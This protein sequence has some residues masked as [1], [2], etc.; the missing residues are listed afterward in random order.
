MACKNYDITISALDIADATGNTPSSL[1]GRV[2]VNYTDCYGDPQTISYNT[3]GSYN[4]AICADDTY[5]L[6]FYYNKNNYYSE[7]IKLREENKLLKQQLTH[8]HITIDVLTLRNKEI[9]KEQP[10]LDL[11]GMNDIDF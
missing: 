3:P 2:F 10:M 11:L 9:F 5:A 4:N 6:F 1:N 8:A 7:C